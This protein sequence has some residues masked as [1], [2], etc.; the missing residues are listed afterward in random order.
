MGWN[1]LDSFVI[2]AQSL[3]ER[4]PRYERSWVALAAGMHEL[5]HTFGLLA[6]KYRG[7]D[8]QGT[9]KPYYKEFWQYLNYKSMMNY[10]Y[11]YSI[12]DYSGGTH[13]KG[14]YNDWGNIDFTFFKN[15]RFNYPVS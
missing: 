11:T 1:N 7:I 14:D 10:L 9:E 13:G 2:S 12:M 4:F 5:G 3:T 15:T 8:N 6:S